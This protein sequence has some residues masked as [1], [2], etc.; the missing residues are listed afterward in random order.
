MWV[1]GQ[2]SGGGLIAIF[3]SWRGPGHDWRL[4]LGLPRC[5]ALPRLICDGGST[6]WAVSTELSSDVYRLDIEKQ[7]SRWQEVK[8]PWRVRW[9]P[10]VVGC[11]GPYIIRFGGRTNELRDVPD[12]LTIEVLDTR[13]VTTITS[14]VLLTGLVDSHVGC[15]ALVT[16]PPTPR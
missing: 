2:P 3:Y 6:L 14:P 8:V 12:C 15:A 13:T 7:A 9:S 1:C 10:H 5:M 4:R 11:W 16:P